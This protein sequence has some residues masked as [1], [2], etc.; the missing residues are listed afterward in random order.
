MRNQGYIPFI[1]AP[2]SYRS[3]DLSDPVSQ[4]QQNSIKAKRRSYTSRSTATALHA[5]APASPNRFAIRSSSQNQLPVSRKSL[6]QHP[7]ALYFNDDVYVGSLSTRKSDRDSVLRPWHGAIF[8]LLDER[9]VEKPAFQR[10]ELDCT[11]CHIA[12]GT[13]GS[14]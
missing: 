4:L 2:I 10:A 1:D 8:Y 11:Q 12:A 3:N 9:K 14:S 7:R 6:P 5:T 13:R